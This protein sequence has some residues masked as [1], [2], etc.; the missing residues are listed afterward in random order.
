MI[1]FTKAIFMV[2]ASLLMLCPSFAQDSHIH[3]LNV[4][5]ISNFLRTAPLRGTPEV[6]S[7]RTIIELPVLGTMREMR[8]I[9]APSMADALAKKSPDI[10]TYIV[11]G[12][13][14][15]LQGRISVTPLGIT[16]VF[17]TEN[18][19]VYLE[20]VGTKVGTTTHKSYATNNL[21]VSFDCGVVDAIE[22]LPDVNRQVVSTYGQTPK[23][24]RIAIATTGEFYRG[25]GGNSLANVKA[26][27]NA[28]LIALNEVYSKEFNVEFELIAGNDVLLFSDPTMDP[29]DPN[30]STA[31]DM[32]AHAAISSEIDAADYDI[33]HLF[34]ESGGS[35]SISASGL[36]GLGVICSATEKGR[37]FSASTS[38]SLAYA[39]FTA[40]FLHEIAHQLGANHSYYGTVNACAAR[41]LGHGYE[42]GSGSTIMGYPGVCS[43]KSFAT[44]PPTVTATHDIALTQ[45]PYFH[46][47]SLTEIISKLETVTCS[48]N[49]A[50][51]NV[52]PTVTV[53]TCTPSI[54]KGTPF[55]LRGAGT[56]ADGDPLKYIWEQY[57]TDS[58]DLAQ[59]AAAGHPDAAANSTTA[60][61]FRSYTPSANGNIR[62]F[63]QLS[64]V[65]NGI[66]GQTADGVLAGEILPQV[67]RN[68]KFRLT[69]RD[70]KGGTAY[71]E[72]SVAVSGSGP[73]TVTTPGTWNI[74]MNANPTINWNANGFT[75]CTNVNIL[76]SMDG[77]NTFPV[78]LAAG[79]PYAGGSAVVTIGQ[80]VQTTTK[81]RLRVECADCVGVKF[82]N[83]NSA[84]FTISNPPCIAEGSSFGNPDDTD[85]VN[86]GPVLAGHASLNLDLKQ[87]TGVVVNSKTLT[88]TTDSATTNVMY[89]NGNTCNGLV[90][91]SLSDIYIDHYDTYTFTAPTSGS[92]TIAPTNSSSGFQSILNLY[93]GTSFTADLNTVLPYD[94]CTNW[95]TSSASNTAFAANAPL[96]AS[97]EGGNQYT[98]VVYGYTGSSTPTNV[99]STTLTFSPAVSEGVI[100]PSGYTYTYLAVHN[101]T[102]AKVSSTADF[103]SLS[104]PDGVTY[105]YTIYGISVRNGDLANV[106]AL[107]G[108]SFANISNLVYCGE[109]SSNTIS[110][111]VIGDMGMPG[112]GECHDGT[113]G[114]YEIVDSKISSTNNDFRITG[115]ITTATPGPVMVEPGDGAVK[116]RAGTSITLNPGFHATAGSSFLAK[117]EACTVTLQEEEP[118]E[119]IV[120]YRYQ[121]EE[122]VETPYIT[123][124]TPTHDL[125]TPT[126][127][128]VMPNP[129][130]S[131]TNLVFNLAQASEV[132]IGVYTSTGQLVEQIANG[133]QLGA[134]THQIQYMPQ[135]LMKGVF[136]VQLRTGKE[137]QVKKLMV[138]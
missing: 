93:S 81:A 78:V 12:I 114:N 130:S 60:P 117:I 59:G 124:V 102:I 31:N 138:Q 1:N 118:L 46:N 53:S 47:H 51:N 132:H 104:P 63:P 95:I 56:D 49:M 23:K 77:G 38:H 91:T 35:N 73:F 83:I 134:G 18:Q 94:N 4:E 90:G 45:D 100:I 48:Q 67:A 42:P 105:T 41:V 92:Y 80:G 62:T 97:L 39:L 122:L 8:A 65:V 99:G 109:V 131:Y 15:D 33:G 98:I 116:F 120:T 17:S 27:I 50:N 26:V 43:I 84:D 64:S 88:T 136:F 11:K 101:G 7:V 128:Q 14:G 125:A 110:L 103:T 52:P 115:T 34:H 89:A 37:G 44:N 137:V 107:E 126:E 24:F 36:A 112:D 71:D 79:V 135:Q 6:A 32:Q 40:T 68:M 72:I 119:E 87:I 20:P 82:F 66:P 76:L 123:E 10:K 113:S 58:D 86:V 55:E 133:Q 108:E 5:S 57:D 111:M 85:P 74:P 30:S 61:L 21:D 29:Y 25:Q 70:E 54:P 75:G 129:F 22:A 3:E 127:L 19:Q 69:A 9:E 16:G 96:T 13:N 2:L 121:A 28:R 106:N